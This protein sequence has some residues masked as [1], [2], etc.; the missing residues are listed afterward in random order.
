MDMHAIDQSVEEDRLEREDSLRSDGGD[1]WAENYQPGT[2]GCHELLDRTSILAAHLDEQL[3]SHPA[4]VHNP[5]W[6]ALAH[7]AATALNDLY[8]KIGAEH[9]TCPEQTE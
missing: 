9:L 5:A 8:Q 3:L 4:C 7:Q 6:F 2:L 1:V